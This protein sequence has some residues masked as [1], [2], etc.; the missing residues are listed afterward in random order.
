[1]LFLDAMEHLPEAGRRELLALTGLPE[2][3]M[4]TVRKIR[5]LLQESGAA[6]RLLKQISDYTD[7]AL[8]CLN[9]LPD[10]S[11][12]RLLIDLTAYM[13]DREV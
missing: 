7:Q 8:K 5:T 1:M 10:N 6:E 3:P 2:Y 12:R 4:D 13:L 9:V 11:Y